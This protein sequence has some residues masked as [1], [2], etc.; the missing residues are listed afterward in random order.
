MSAALI[1][2]SK[3]MGKK[4]VIFSDSTISLAFNFELKKEN[5]TL[6]FT[7]KVFKADLC[8]SAL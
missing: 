6:V 4:R 1:S 2:L 7:I 5:S 8:F 3:K